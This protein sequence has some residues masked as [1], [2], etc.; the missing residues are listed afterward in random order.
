M[1]HTSSLNDK[2]GYFTLDVINPAKTG[3]AAKCYNNY[4]PGTGYEYCNLNYNMVGTIIERVSGQRFDKYVKTHI[5]DP[6]ALYGGYE[7]GALD[8][9]KFVTLYE[10]DSATQ[11]LNAAP[12]AYNPRTDEISHYE[13]GYS[14]PYFP[15]Q[16]A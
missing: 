6:L 1:S 2:Q 13:M 5:L 16:A 3:D 4:E 15:R 12:N 10:Y 7:V 8:A 14:T 9:S 11:K